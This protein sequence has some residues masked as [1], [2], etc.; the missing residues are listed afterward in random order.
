[1]WQ[2]AIYRTLSDDP[3]ELWANI[4]P[5]SQTPARYRPRYRAVTGRL[6]GCG[7][8]TGQRPALL[9]TWCP[10]RP[11]ISIRPSR[12]KAG[13]VKPSVCLGDNGEAGGRRPGGT[14][15]KCSV[16]APLRFRSRG[17][18]KNLLLKFLGVVPGHARESTMPC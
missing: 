12:D 13:V 1:M 17:G 4:G 2:M 15:S 11:Y 9:A 6:R 5:S 8:S 16:H 10:Y 3:A 14:A 7:R 18:C